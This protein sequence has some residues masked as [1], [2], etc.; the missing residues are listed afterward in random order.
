[1]L[2][3]QGQ[4]IQLIFDRRGFF[5]EVLPLEEQRHHDDEKVGQKHI[6]TIYEINPAR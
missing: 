4:G 3:G 5:G 1:M 6:V 2:G